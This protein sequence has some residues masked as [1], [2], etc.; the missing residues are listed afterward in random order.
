MPV[1]QTRKPGQN[2]DAFKQ[3]PRDLLG[4]DS[5]GVCARATV[6]H[7]HGPLIQLWLDQ[8]RCSGSLALRHGERRSDVCRY[9]EC[10]GNLPDTNRQE[11]TRVTLEYMK[12]FDPKVGRARQLFGWECISAVIPHRF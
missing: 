12:Q 10:F 3:T 6:H 4:R 2:A 9:H 11:L 8:V 1:V 5:Q 7:G